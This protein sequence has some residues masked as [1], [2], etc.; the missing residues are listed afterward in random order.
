MNPLSLHHINNK[1]PYCVSQATEGVYLFSTA[2]GVNYSIAFMEDNPLGNCDTYQFGIRRINNV[3]TPHDPYVECTILAI[4]D[5]FFVSNLNV[6]LYI[7]DTSDHRE[8]ARNRLFLTWF[9]HNAEPERFTICT[10]NAEVEGEGFYAAIIVE[11]R[12]PKLKEITE[13]FEQTAQMLIEE[14]PENN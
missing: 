2:K 5:E 10:A 12:N 1:A 6:L 13:E 9:E 3:S 7:C 8:E 11:K 4:I 14:K